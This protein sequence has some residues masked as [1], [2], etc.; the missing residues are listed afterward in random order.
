MVAGV[1]WC[2]SGAICMPFLSFISVLIHGFVSGFHLG[3][4]TGYEVFPV[5]I[6][7]D[8]FCAPEQSTQKFDL[9]IPK[10]GPLEIGWQ[11]ACLW[12]FLRPAPTGP[13]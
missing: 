11:K 10:V 2:V 9:Y 5:S 7:R 6:L 8:Y 4:T 1:L 3:I 13:R 12:P